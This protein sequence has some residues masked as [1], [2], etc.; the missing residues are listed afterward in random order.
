MGLIGSPVPI[1][2]CP[3][4]GVDLV[5]AELEVVAERPPRHGS[6]GGAV[7]EDNIR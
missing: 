2:S 1:A 3:A 4:T 7:A 5:E 6:G